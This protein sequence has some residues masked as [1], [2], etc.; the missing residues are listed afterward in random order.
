MTLSVAIFNND[1]PTLAELLAQGADP[2]RIDNPYDGETPAQLAARLG[3]ME[4]LRV[5]ISAGASLSGVI[6]SAACREASLDDVLDCVQLLLT[7]GSD[8]NELSHALRVTSH[9]EVMRRLL[10]SGAYI[11]A[12][13]TDGRTALIHAAYHHEADC[14]KFLLSNGAASEKV[15]RC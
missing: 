14:L 8:A 4:C 1:P 12:R 3:R 9:I 11:E 5:L 6:A 2:D 7:V 10:E 15:R 13:D